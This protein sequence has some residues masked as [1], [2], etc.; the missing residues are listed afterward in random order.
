MTD[1]A[2]ILQRLRRGPVHTTELRREGYSGNPAQRVAELEAAGHRI[3]HE[4]TPW[5]DAHGK[6]RPGTTYTLLDV[7]VSG[8]PSS[9]PPPQAAA[10]PDAG[11]FDAPERA[12]YMD[13]DTYEAA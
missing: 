6:T 3:H 1:A 12:A 10:D 8:G 5:K 13:P 4:R 2:R 11:L 9:V 7:E